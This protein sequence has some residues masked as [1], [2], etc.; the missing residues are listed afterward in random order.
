LEFSREQSF[1]ATMLYTCIFFLP[2]WELTLSLPWFP[3]APM[4]A[5]LI[6]AMNVATIALIRVGYEESMRQLFFGFL[7]FAALFVAFASAPVT[8]MTYVPVYAVLWLTVLI[9]TPVDYVLA[10]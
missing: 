10:R 3:L 7:F 4:N 1:L 9:P 2:F 5:N 8:S 6:A